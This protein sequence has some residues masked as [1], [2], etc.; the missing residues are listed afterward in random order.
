M[1]YNLIETPTGCQRTKRLGD[2]ATALEGKVAQVVEGRGVGILVD[3][4]LALLH[5][6]GHVQL[7]ARWQQRHHGIWGQTDANYLAKLWHSPVVYSQIM[8]ILQ[9]AMSGGPPWALIGICSGVMSKAVMS[10]SPP[11]SS[12]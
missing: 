4:L 2:A 12:S 10:S 11:P 6:V 1:F 5:Q 8:G 9:A 3:A 7:L